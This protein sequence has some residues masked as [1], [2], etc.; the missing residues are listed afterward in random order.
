MFEGRRQ[1]MLHH[2]MFDPSW[3][4]G[5][6]SCSADA[7]ER[8][9]GLVAHLPRA[10]RRSPPSRARRSPSSRR[11]R[12]RKGW[13]FPWYSS[14]GGD[15]NYDFHTTIDESVAPLE[16]NYRTRADLEAAAPAHGCSPPRSR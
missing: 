3:E 12:A 13:T 14:Y 10:T 15:F 11:Y 4:E 16:V 7:D 9:A 1:L 6:P 2:F 5:C 8:S